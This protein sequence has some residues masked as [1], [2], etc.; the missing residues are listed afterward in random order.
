VVGVLPSINAETG[1]PAPAG[2][3]SS[4][5]AET[6]VPA[7]IGAINY[8]EKGAPTLGE[9]TI[10]SISQEAA[11]GV[12]SSINAE[13]RVPAVGVLPL[14][15]NAET[16]VPADGEEAVVVCAD[17]LVLRS[18]SGSTTVDFKSTKRDSADSLLMA[19]A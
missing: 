5:N 6:R 10:G 18:C 7:D 16:R 14:I 17:G 13:T 9:G 12:L 8:A 4:I 3:L 2:V 19:Q 11:A 15:S 1:V